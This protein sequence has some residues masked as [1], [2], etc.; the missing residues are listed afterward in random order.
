MTD[1]T[2]C[3]DAACSSRAHCARATATGDPEGHTTHFE[4]IR[5]PEDQCCGYYTMNAETRAEVRRMLETMF[6]ERPPS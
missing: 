2:R 5:R 3:N 4:S 1:L 6:G